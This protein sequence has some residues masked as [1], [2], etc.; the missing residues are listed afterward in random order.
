MNTKLPEM[1]KQGYRIISTEK[2]ESYLELVPDAATQFTYKGYDVAVCQSLV[3]DLVLVAVL[4]NGEIIA[5][6][7]TVQEAIEFVDTQL[8][9]ESVESIKDYLFDSYF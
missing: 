6:C 5:H 8:G 3:F 2:S 4:F 7:F 1:N 9:L